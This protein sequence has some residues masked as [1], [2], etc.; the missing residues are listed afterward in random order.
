MKPKPFW[1]LNHFTIP[2]FTEIPFTHNVH[3]RPR[4]LGIRTLRRFIDFLEKGSETCAPSVTRR[5]GPGRRPSVDRRD[6]DMN[7][8]DVKVCSLRLADVSFGSW[9][10]RTQSIKTRRLR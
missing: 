3:A 1:L 5:S 8:N 9:L 2:L 6:L 10:V 4:R 7:W